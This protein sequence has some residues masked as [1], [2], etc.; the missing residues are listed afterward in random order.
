VTST[1]YDE[2]GEWLDERQ[3]RFIA[4][5]DQIW[6]KPEVALE[7]FTACKLQS[8]DLAADGFTIT[9]NVGDLPTAFMAEWTQGEGGPVIGFLYPGPAGR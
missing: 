2:V 3:G 1:V 6:Q 9:R 8:E 4:I 5:S 7:E